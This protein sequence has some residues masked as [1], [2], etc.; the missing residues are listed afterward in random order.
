MVGCFN[1][2]S[3]C[4]EKA[5]DFWW[6]SSTPTIATVDAQGVVRSQGLGKAVIRVSAVR[7]SLNFDEVSLC[8][9]PFGINSGFTGILEV[10]QFFEE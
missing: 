4:G 6:S 9:Q 1:H 2:E 10:L 7:D 8:L 5:A 3:G